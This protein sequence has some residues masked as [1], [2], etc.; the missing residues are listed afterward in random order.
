M[1]EDTTI[2]VALLTGWSHDYLVVLTPVRGS[3]SMDE[4]RM[5]SLIGPRDVIA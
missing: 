5:H 3:M 2:A 1:T 4:V